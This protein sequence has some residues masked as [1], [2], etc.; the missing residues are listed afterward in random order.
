M[1]AALVA[2]AC[3]LQIPEWLQSEIRASN[4]EW[5]VRQAE[6]ERRRGILDYTVRHGLPGVEPPLLTAQADRAKDTIADI[7]RR[8][9][10]QLVRRFAPSVPARSARLEVLIG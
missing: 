7:T 3:V 2:H 9:F 4:A 8:T 10:D 6:Y 5:A 1:V